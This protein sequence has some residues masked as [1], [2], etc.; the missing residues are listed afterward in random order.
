MQTSYNVGLVCVYISQ[1]TSQSRW[2]NN[3]IDV[4]VSSSPIHQQQ[5]PFSSKSSDIGN[6]NSCHDDRVGAKP[7][8]RDI[9]GDSRDIQDGGNTRGGG[10]SPRDRRIGSRNSPRSTTTTTSSSHRQNTSQCCCVLE[11]LIHLFQP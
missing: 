3:G 6:K 7:L 9:R 1:S 11:I 8:G 4:S 10:G 5:R 2:R